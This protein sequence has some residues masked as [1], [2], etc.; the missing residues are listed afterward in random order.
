MLIRHY[1]IEIAGDCNYSEVIELLLEGKI[2]EKLTG[3][4]LNN[5]LLYSHIAINR[6]IDEERKHDRFLLTSEANASLASMSSGEQKKA[7]MLHI[8]SSD[9]GFIIVDNVTDNLDAGSQAAI[10]SSLQSMSKKIP[11][12]QIIS[13][14][15][16]IFPFISQVIRINNNMNNT[17]LSIEEYL[18]ISQTSVIA[19]GDGALPLPVM[20]RLEKYRG[21][22]L[23]EFRNVSVS[24]NGRQ[25]LE[26]INWI[27]NPGE[28]WQLAGP[29]GS[30]KTTMLGLITGDNPKAFGQEIYL[31]GMRKGSGET[32]WDIKKNIGYFTP[33][34]AS[35]FSRL[36]TVENMIL[37]GFLDSVG[38][39]ANPTE[40]QIKA[41]HEWLHL[42]GI[43]NDRKKV[44]CF[45]PL[46]L[47]R[48]VMVIRAM[49]KYPPLLILDEPTA[50]LD[51]NN[52]ALFTALVNKIAAESSTAII[53]VS[54]R[55][56]PGLEPEFVYDL[57][58]GTNGSVGQT[59][60]FN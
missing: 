47:Q 43:Y 11:I 1:A 44:F 35:F 3:Y 6:Y 40:L 45:L 26:N 12:F 24:Y 21:S 22:S 58:P 4:S 55:D 14:R 29:N 53:Y 56:E 7:L 28:F 33:D 60:T 23:V 38:L 5:G 31:F 30:G 37:S 16:D 59:R 17:I 39:Y 42:T 27:I 8:L 50:G 13:R 49:V 34:I 57:S 15:G 20:S 41:T 51:D 46:G 2:L 9:P 32:V 10:L 54:H 18:R 25:V 48:L 52:A 36:D 19:L